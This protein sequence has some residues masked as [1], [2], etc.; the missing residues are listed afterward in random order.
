MLLTKSGD[1]MQEI[2]GR[3]YSRN[4][5]CIDLVFASNNKSYEFLIDTGF[6]GSLCIPRDLAIELN[7]QID[8]EVPYYGIGGTEHIAEISYLEL[9]WFEQIIEVSVL[10]NDGQDFLLGT[11]LLEN[12]ELYINF[13]TG[14]VLITETI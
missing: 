5:P 4:E 7:L 1:L 12:K 2:R 11:Q 13:K 9:F 6:N 14:E 8:D 10:I 3:L